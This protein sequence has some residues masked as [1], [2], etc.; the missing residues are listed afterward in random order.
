MET[1]ITA[2]TPEYEEVWVLIHFF[3]KLLLK[4]QVVIFK[5]FKNERIL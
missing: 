1:I 2:V 3:F 4:P 5:H